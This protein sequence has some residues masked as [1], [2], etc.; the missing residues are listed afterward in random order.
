MTLLCSQCG[1][2]AHSPEAL[3]C[4]QCA[5]RLP[6]LPRTPVANVPVLRAPEG[7][8]GFLAAVVVLLVLLI[9]GFAV[10]ALIERALR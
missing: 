9:V 3:F 4:G 5:T 2:A 7:R 10:L 8:S 6:S 1:A